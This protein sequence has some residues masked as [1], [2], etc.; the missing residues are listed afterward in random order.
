VVGANVTLRAVFTF[1]LMSFINCGTFTQNGAT[2][3]NTS[4]SNTKVSASSPANAALISDCTFTSS[5]TGH[6]MEIAGTAASIALDGNTFSGY[7]A[8]DGSTGNEAI[9]VNIATGTMTIT[10]TGGGSTPSIRTAGCTVTV[11][12]NVVLTVTGIVTG[13]D[14]VIYE[15]GT[16]TVLD[17]EQNIAGTTFEYTY[18]GG[19]AGDD[20][21]V[22][23]FLAGYRPFYIRAYELAATDASLPAAQQID[24]DYLT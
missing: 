18:P 10:I 20:I 1:N 23:V 22:G 2:I 13:S 16:T 19:D 4:F 6:A 21:D 14:V 24:R 5:G 17:S 12:N 11:V 7:A 15:A 3:T 8:S 9:Y